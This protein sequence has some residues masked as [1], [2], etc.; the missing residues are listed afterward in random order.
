MNNSKYFS[1]GTSRIKGFLNTLRSFSTPFNKISEEELSL[2]TKR[3][4]FFTLSLI[5]TFLVIYGMLF[6]TFTPNIIFK[7]TTTISNWDTTAHN[8]IAKFFIEELF[9]NFRI[10]GWDMGWF[11]GMPMLTFYFPLP[12]ILIALLSKILVFNISFK[13]V[14]ILGC[15]ILPVAVYYF[16]KSLKFKYPYPELAAIGALAFLYMK[17]FLFDG[18]NLLGTLVGQFSYS[19]SLGFMFIFLGSLYRGMEKGKFDWLF[20]LNCVILTS[21]VLTHLVILMATLI[22]VPGIF[23][24]RI[25][26]KTAK[27][28]IAVFIIGFLLSA[29]WS[30]PFVLQTEWTSPMLWKSARDL[31]EIFP[32]ELIPAMVFS[33]IGIFFAILKKDKRVIP[34]IWSIIAFIIL[35]F[36]YDVSRIYN[37][38]FKPFLFVFIYLLAAYGLKNIYWTIVTVISYL[39]PVKIRVTIFRSIAV[40]LI[41]I[42]VISVSITIIADEP[43]AKNLAE[44]FYNGQE[45]VEE[46][47]LYN[48][49]MEYLDSL[50]YGRV[51]HDYN[52]D[53][54]IKFGGNR[55]FELIPYWTKQPTLDGLLTESAFSSHFHIIS[56][57]HF[58]LR[59]DPTLRDYEAA[60]KYLIY[61]NTSYI[62]ASTPEIIEDLDN[63]SRVKLI[64]TIGPYNFYET[65]GPHNYVEIVENI[66]YRYKI[67]DWL[68][69]IKYWYW[70]E[71]NIDNPVIYDDG[72]KE[73]EQFEVTERVIDL[74]DN[75]VNTKGKIIS[76]NIEREKIEF[77]TT[78][79]GIP[80]LIKVSYFPNW[81]AIGAEGPYLAA[82]SIIMVIPTQENVTI[83]YG[84]TFANRTGIAL[85]VFGWVVIGFLLILNIF[86][87]LKKKKNK[88]L[89]N[90]S[91]N[92]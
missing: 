87:Y 29:F 75:P 52:D 11:T 48:D 45:E 73:L 57:D 72:S 78:A 9:P 84:T 2:F 12:Y 13:L 91:I 36:S 33:I 54:M 18:G 31:S 68:T 58:K 77:T 19:L 85:S 34:V 65:I 81:K 38:R 25:K 17:S 6:Y 41:P 28:I 3:R 51:I 21:I 44:S 76:E 42:I 22:I 61:F 60:M 66:P 47:E 39:K 82:P 74:A 89:S 14:T 30:M 20:V 50:P 23:L 53:L 59:D 62:L 1:P 90:K 4:L 16:G 32:R 70:Y 7:D 86:S 88:K 83:Y 43:R 27:Y 35:I 71:E 55:A 24:L 10:T 8:Y 26:W 37:I 92:F 64:N 15:F 80:H 49:I 79:V 69:E 63:D 5:I 46:W 40:I 56:E 67:D